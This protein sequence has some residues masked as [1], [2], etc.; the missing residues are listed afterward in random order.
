MANVYY[1]EEHEWIEVL[2]DDKV[3]IGITEF[4]Q[5]E[6][7]D[8]VYVELPEVGDEFDDGEEFGSVESVKSVS[9]IMTPL[10]G[11]V[12]AVNEALED[13][14]EL[15]NDDAMGE[16][17]LI[18]LELSDEFDSDQLLSKEAYDEMIAE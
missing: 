16:G 1:T 18:E 13:E 4:A 3:R 14:P 12:T 11:T 7:G 2:K 8:I 15:V 10:A 6:L 9:A 5:E 17:W